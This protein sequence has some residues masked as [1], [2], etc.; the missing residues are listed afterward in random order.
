MEDDGVADDGPHGGNE[1]ERQLHPRQS[2]LQKSPTQR[3]KGLLKGAA[4][5]AMPRKKDHKVSGETVHE[6]HE[7]KPLDLSGPHPPPGSQR[8]PRKANRNVLD[9]ALYGENEVPQEPPRPHAPPDGQRSPSKDDN[10]RDSGVHGV[11]EQPQNPLSPNLPSSS[12]VLPRKKG[13]DLP[14]EAVHGG[15]EQGLQDQFGPHLP[16]DSQRMPGKKDGSVPD[17]V[18]GENEEPQDLSSPHPDSSSQRMPGKEGAS[19][20]DDGAHGRNKEGDQVRPRSSVLKKSR[21][22]K[23]RLSFNLD[24]AS[25]TSSRP[26]SHS[27]EARQPR[28]L[29]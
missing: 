19:V 5:L 25:S 10:V 21:T 2:V 4:Y 23:E 6:E 18:H 29:R 28:K 13:G 3:I 1:E 12:Q 27:K 8:T 24:R 22:L 11:H 7:Q 20:L 15:Q 16:S 17:D 9:D 26:Q 14:S